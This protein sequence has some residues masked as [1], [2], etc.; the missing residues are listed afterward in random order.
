MIMRVSSPP[1][2]DIPIGSP[3][4]KYRGKFREKTLRSSS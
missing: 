4:L 2:K 3:P 1:V